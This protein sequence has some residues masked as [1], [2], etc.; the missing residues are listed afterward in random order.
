MWLLY[1]YGPIYAWDSDHNLIIENGNAY[2]ATVQTD[3]IYFFFNSSWG[4]V[5]TLQAKKPG[6]YYVSSVANG[7]AIYTYHDYSIEQLTSN[8]TF[9]YNLQPMY[10]ITSIWI[11]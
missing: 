4:G 1:N 3:Y 8:D 9:P 7:N 2:N 6:T 10:S 5:Y 11:F